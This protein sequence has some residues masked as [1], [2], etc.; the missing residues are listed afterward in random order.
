MWKTGFQAMKLGIVTFLVPFVLLFNPAMIL[1]GTP[2]QII[3]VFITCLTGSLFL[4][5]GF[6]AYFLSHLKWWQVVLFLVA[7]FA[8]YAPYWQINLLGIVLAV[9]VLAMQYLDWRSHR[10]HTESPA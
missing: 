10:F 7:G 3:S 1:I 4:A 6:E 2:V 5:A 8:L 9:P